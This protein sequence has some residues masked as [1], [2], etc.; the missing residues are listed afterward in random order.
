[1]CLYSYIL[2]YSSGF[3]HLHVV[4]ADLSQKGGIIIIVQLYIFV[5][6]IALGCDCC[7]V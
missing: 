6:Y 5:T 2:W 3:M 1:M 4:S 7:V